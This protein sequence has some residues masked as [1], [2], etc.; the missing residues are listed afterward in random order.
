MQSLLGYSSTIIL[1]SRTRQYILI[2]K[3]SL[4]GEEIKKLDFGQVL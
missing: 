2:N 4:F 1:L 3:L